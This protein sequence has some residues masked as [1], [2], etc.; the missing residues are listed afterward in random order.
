MEV[1][2][3]EALSAVQRAVRDYLHD[4]SLAR[5]GQVEIAWRRLRQLDSVARWRHGP[6]GEPHRRLRRAAPQFSSVV[7]ETPSAAR[8]ASHGLGR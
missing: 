5:A 8:R 6:V 3:R 7:S 4:P 2:R 1:Q